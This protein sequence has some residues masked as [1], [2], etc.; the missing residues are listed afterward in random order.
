MNAE[1]CH[2]RPSQLIRSVSV[3]ASR[4]LAPHFRRDGGPCFIVDLRNVQN[5]KVLITKPST[6]TNGD[7]FLQCGI[8][9]QHS[10]ISWIISVRPP[11]CFLRLFV[12][13]DVTGT[14]P[15][16][17]NTRA[18]NCASEV[19]IRSTQVRSGSSF[20]QCALGEFPP[21]LVVQHH[22]CIS[23]NVGIE[24]VRFTSQ[25][26]VPFPPALSVSGET[27]VKRP[28]CQASFNP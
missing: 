27:V 7:R 16:G 22:T 21:F 14:R 18:W 4:V 15:S 5:H 24:R 3:P 25:R 13:D 20:S 11:V 6:W 10:H 19:A 1:A 28:F 23:E 17:A 8:E 9:I 12:S 2:S 26:F